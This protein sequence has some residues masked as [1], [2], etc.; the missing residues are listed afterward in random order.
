MQIQ[1]SQVKY[2]TECKEQC[3]Q[4]SNYK[5]A[6]FQGKQCST[7]TPG[8]PQSDIISDDWKQLEYAVQ[9]KLVN[10]R[11]GKSTVS[12][13][14]N[15]MLNSRDE[16]VNLN[17]VL[18]R[19]AN[20]LQVFH[21]GPENMNHFFL[22]PLDKIVGAIVPDGM[23]WPQE[24]QPKSMTD[25]K[26]KSGPYNREQLAK[27]LAAITMNKYMVSLNPLIA[28]DV[29]DDPNISG[30]DI[31]KRKDGK[32]AATH[33]KEEELYKTEV[34]AM[35]T[36][37]DSYNA[38]LGIGDWG[39]NY[40]DDIVCGQTPVSGASSPVAAP[41]ATPVHAAPAPAPAPAPDKC[42][43]VRKI[44]SQ[45]APVLKSKGMVPGGFKNTADYSRFLV[46]NRHI[47]LRQ[48]IMMA[49]ELIDAGKVSSLTSKAQET[50]QGLYKKGDKNNAIG[51]S[52]SRNMRI[53]QLYKCLLVPEPTCQ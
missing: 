18:G 28:P 3:K 34:K 40:A 38:A 17:A 1:C 12:S 7:Q 15:D 51:L 37:L 27:V 43:N 21:H 6:T 14:V 31:N 11:G 25:N 33:A 48:Q 26:I 41:V 30:Q 35:T 10:V 46:L 8:K 5:T 19:N 29:Y 42:K 44:A 2:T 23:V 39:T 22:Q 24:L 49:K 20:S 50:V 47:T 4:K 36:F 52:L 13:L 53:H 32:D 45:G 16:K 9:L